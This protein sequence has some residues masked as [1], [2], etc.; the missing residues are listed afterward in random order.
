LKGITKRFS[1]PLLPYK[2]GDIPVILKSAEGTVGGKN[3]LFS[4]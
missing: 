3:L 4:E 1:P 2:F